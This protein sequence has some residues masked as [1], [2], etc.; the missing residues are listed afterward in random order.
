MLLLPDLLGFWLTGS[1]GAE[2][3][4]ASTTGL[5]DVRSGEWATELAERVGVPPG[6][7]PPLRSA[8]TV[9]RARCCRTSRALSASVPTCP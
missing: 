4:N 7:L 1:A 3:T 5:Y 2:R 8:G 6:I 9:D